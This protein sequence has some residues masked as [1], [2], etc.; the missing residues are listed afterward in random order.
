M[1]SSSLGAHLR[2]HAADAEALPDYLDAPAP[3][4]LRRFII[5]MAMLSK[6]GDGG[7]R[8]LKASESSWLRRR[9]WP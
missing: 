1:R 4:R 3:C 2:G 7:L 5:G 9:N 6:A 8:D